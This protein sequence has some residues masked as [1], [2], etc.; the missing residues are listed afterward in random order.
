MSKTGATDEAVRRAARSIHNAMAD[1]IDENPCGSCLRAVQEVAAQI[2]P[3]TERIVS[4]ADLIFLCDMA[5]LGGAD[6]AELDAY[7]RIR[8]LIGGE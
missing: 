4:V 1:E 8:A 5:A 2:V 7:S 3:P 6:P